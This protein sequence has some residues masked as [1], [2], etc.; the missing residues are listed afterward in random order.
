MSGDF[1]RRRPDKYR[2]LV[3]KSS[4]FSVKGTGQLI[5]G[6][7]TTPEDAVTT[8]G[9]GHLISRYRCDW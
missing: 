2:P 6:K 5:D 1:A 3:Q 7:L 4:T 9:S 8:I